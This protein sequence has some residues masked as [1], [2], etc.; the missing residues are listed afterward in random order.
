M[1]RVEHGKWIDPDQVADHVDS[2]QVLEP[3]APHLLR[4]DTTTAPPASSASAIVDHLSSI[5][6]NG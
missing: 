1:D 6:A 4:L 3:D 2:H 5:T